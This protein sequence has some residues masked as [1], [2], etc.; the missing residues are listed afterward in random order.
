LLRPLSRSL[1]IPIRLCRIALC[2]PAVAPVS[3][4]ASDRPREAKIATTVASVRTYHRVSRKQ[5]EFLPTGLISR[6]AL[7]F[8]GLSAEVH[9]EGIRDAG[10]RTTRGSRL[11]VTKNISRFLKARTQ[12]VS[13]SARDVHSGR[14]ENKKRKRRPPDKPT[15]IRLVRTVAAHHSVRMKVG[16]RRYS[17][18]SRGYYRSSRSLEMGKRKCKEDTLRSASLLR[19]RRTLSRPWRSVLSGPCDVLIGKYITLAR[20]T[21]RL[22][23]IRARFSR[24]ER[25]AFGRKY[26]LLRD[27]VDARSSWRGSLV[28]GHVSLKNDGYV[29]HLPFFWPLVSP[30]TFG[31]SGRI[32]IGLARHRADD[33]VARS[34]PDVSRPSSSPLLPFL[35]LLP[36]PRAISFALRVPRLTVREADLASW[37]V[38]VHQVV[39]DREDRAGSI[40]AQSDPPE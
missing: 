17:R 33:I 29:A 12:G 21:S 28:R 39:H 3:T 27:T 6:S 32:W 24:A 18:S 34:S 22:H 36:L 26:T 8:F 25:P 1:R 5:K 19:S 38:R 10:Y 16:R 4:F 15:A 20:A 30:G 31:A 9:D 35:P 13:P 40:N 7:R 14:Q 37:V 11:K 2:P 23:R